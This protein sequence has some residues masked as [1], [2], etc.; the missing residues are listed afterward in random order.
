MS[1][2]MNEEFRKALGALNDPAEEVETSDEVIDFK[3]ALCNKVES[4]RLYRV[5]LGEYGADWVKLP[6]GWWVLLNCATAH[7]RCSRCLGGA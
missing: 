4:G 7:V 2:W 1:D 5:S 3:C 6:A